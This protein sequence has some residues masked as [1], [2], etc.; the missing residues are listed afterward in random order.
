MSDCPR[1]RNGIWCPCDSCI[2]QRGERE[3]TER[4]IHGGER[5]R[6]TEEEREWVET[7]RALVARITAP[8]HTMHAAYLA[9]MVRII[10][11]LT[12]EKP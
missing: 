5:P 6:L 4:A 3:I 9:Q 1:H 12:S 11:R 2:D 7:T 10:D 8:S